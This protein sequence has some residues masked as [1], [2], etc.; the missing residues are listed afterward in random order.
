[1]RIHTTHTR[2]AA[3]RELHRINR[4]MI[5]ASVVLTGVLTDVAANAFPGRTVKSVTKTKATGG[6][7]GD[8][9]GA[10]PAA[11]P[12]VREHWHR[13]N[14]LRVPPA[15]R[16]PLRNPR[17]LG[18]PHLRR[19]R[20]A[21]RETVPAQES[22]PARASPAQESAPTQE[23]AAEPAQE[24]APVQEAAPEPAQESAPV[25]SGGS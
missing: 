4:W 2:D 17:L 20:Q 9:K 16:H 19:K 18:N 21:A 5:A 12:P 10:L 3:L 11:Y 24:S 6:H 13:P 22:E 1:M 14:R 8:T 7:S 23:A 25:V 15:N